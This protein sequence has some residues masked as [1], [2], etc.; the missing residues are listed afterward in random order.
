[1]VVSCKADCGCGAMDFGLSSDFVFFL[2]AIANGIDEKMY[3]KRVKIY[4]DKKQ[5]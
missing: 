4:G 2:P 3:F 1:M 5:V